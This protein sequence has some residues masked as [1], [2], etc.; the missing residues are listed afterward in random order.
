MKMRPPATPIINIDP[1]FSVWTE[2]TVLKNTVHWTGKPNTMRGRVFV[3]GTE[4]H[5]LGQNNQPRHQPVEV[6]NM[7]VE[8]TEIDAYSTIITYSNEIIRL[9]VHFTSPT[10]VEHLYLASRPVAYCKASYESLD[11][12]NHK[13]SVKF[14]ASEELVLEHKGEGRAIANPVLIE[15]ITAIKMG[16]GK[17]NVLWRS[18]DDIRIDWGY[19]YLAVKGEGK[20]GHT[21]FNDMY[22]A[23]V[24]AELENEALFLFA[25]DDIESIQYFGEN[26]KA[27]WKKRRK[28]HRR[29]HYR[30][31]S[32]L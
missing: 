5:F 6:P 2:A 12:K 19:L 18:G 26:L 27:Y 13:V 3:D 21:V 16:N 4:Y 22:A 8:R 20:T 31:C 15:G 10:L 23:T 28:N 9:T 32:R 11:G 17:Q 30:G 25:Y 7:T 14:V 29:S 24:E 1:Y